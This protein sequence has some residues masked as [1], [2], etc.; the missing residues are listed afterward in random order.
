MSSET[1]LV[2]EDDGILAAHLHD[3]L[4]R[5]GYTVPEP[6][7][8]GEAALATLVTSLPDLVLM[9]IYLAGPMNGVTAAQRIHAYFDIPVIYLTAFSTEALLHQAK[10]TTPYGYLIK[11]VLERELLATLEMT[12]YRHQIDRRLKN[13]EERLALAL[14]GADIGI[15]DWNV[16][17]DTALYSPRWT[18]MLG[19]QPEEIAPHRH[20][21]EK[22]VH[23]EDLSAVLEALN[24]HLENRT[25]FFESEHRLQHQDG[26]WV[27]VLSKGK[28]TER[29]PYGQPVRVCGTHLDISKQKR[30]EEE[31]RRLAATDP[32]TNAFNRRYFLQSVNKEINRAQRYGRPLALIMSDI[33]HF[34]Q[35]NDTFGHER[36]DEILREIAARVQQRLR[37][38]DVFVRWG[39]EEFL[40]L[41]TETTLQQAVILAETLLA[42]LHDASFADIGPVTASFGVTNYRFGE[43]LDQWLKRVDNLMYQA[44]SE[45]RNR[46][47]SVEESLNLSSCSG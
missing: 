37:Q 2:V 26:H 18:E 41:A 42:A 33:D 35:I 4:T 12:L 45:G 17:T 13:S 31:L 8:T 27:W 46:V 28:V 21:W 16:Y 44:K 47:C 24:A 22:R 15:W 30:L 23:P 3:M 1:I 36:G 34:K 25:P 43:T 11:P 14:W 38:T 9:D 29:D 6:V 19:Y 40:I 20:G 39:G 32:L 5:C 7:A 10:I